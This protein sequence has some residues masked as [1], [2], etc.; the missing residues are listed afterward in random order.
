MK[1]D[2]GQVPRQF[3]HSSNVCV[4]SMRGTFQ[5]PGQR[6]SLPISMNTLPFEKIRHLLSGK[7]LVRR[8]PN[9]P[10]A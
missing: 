9:K 6:V 5:S 2:Q 4:V 1:D 3:Y 10:T 8:N 7:P